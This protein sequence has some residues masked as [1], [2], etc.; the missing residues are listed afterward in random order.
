MGVWFDLEKV[1]DESFFDTAPI[2]FAY[3]M[4]LKASADDSCGNLR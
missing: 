3:T 1:T 2:R 4:H